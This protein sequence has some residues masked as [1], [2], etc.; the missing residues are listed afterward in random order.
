MTIAIFWG[1]EREC[2]REREREREREIF[3]IILFIYAWAR[4]KALVS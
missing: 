1:G 3:Y 2:V 4:Q